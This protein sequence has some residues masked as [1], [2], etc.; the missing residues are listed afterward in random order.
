MN[1]GSGGVKGACGRL[2]QEAVADAMD[3]EE[4]TGLIGVGLELL[5]ELDYMRIHSAR[6]G[7]ELVADRKSVV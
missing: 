4:V 6:V 5:T 7:E 2:R 1:D 3:S